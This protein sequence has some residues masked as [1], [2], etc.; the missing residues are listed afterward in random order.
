MGTLAKMKQLASH[1]NDITVT[2]SHSS[3]CLRDLSRTSHSEGH[4]LRDTLSQVEDVQE[5]RRP[6]R[7]A[8]V[9]QQDLLQGLIN[10]DLI[11]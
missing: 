9:R 2:S 6:K 4:G 11:K 7:R 5:S 1:S 3:P 8:A 10:E